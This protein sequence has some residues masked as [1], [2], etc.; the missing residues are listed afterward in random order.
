MFHHRSCCY[1][2]ALV[3]MSNSKFP[4]TKVLLNDL[5]RTKKR[6]V[7]YIL[8]KAYLNDFNIK[9]SLLE[10]NFGVSKYEKK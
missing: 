6:Y 5:T 7:K 4:A 3:K 9:T 10:V 8:P 1:P 2:F